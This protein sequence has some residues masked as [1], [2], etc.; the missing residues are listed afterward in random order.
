M[1]YQDYLPTNWIRHRKDDDHPLVALRKEVDSLFDDF[2]NGFFNGATE[3]N[4]RSNVSETDAEFC[5]TAELPGMTEADVDV[6]IAGDRII[7]K[8][9]KKSEKDEESDEKGR[10]FHRIERMSGAFQRMMTLPFVIDA[11]TVEAVVKD[12]ILTVTIP[13][14]PETVAGSKKIKVAHGK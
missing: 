8:G 5:V 9:E 7:I 11:D 6:S 12:G 2:G 4:V 10:H 3:M 1:S 14:P 13:K